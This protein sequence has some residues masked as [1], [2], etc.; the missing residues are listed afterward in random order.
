[1]K[2]VEGIDLHKFAHVDDDA[3]ARVF[4]SCPHVRTINV[5]GCRRIGGASMKAIAEMCNEVR[6][7]NLTGNPNVT[8]S[9][10]DEVIRCCRNL[11]SLSLAGCDRIPETTVSGKYAQYC[12]IFDEEEEGPWTA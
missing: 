8:V 10:L 3:A 1:M 4:L 9:M 7:L 11:G 5:Y 6:E 2:S 12:D